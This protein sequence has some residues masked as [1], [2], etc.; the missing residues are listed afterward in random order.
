MFSI[1]SGIRLPLRAGLACV[2]RPFVI[3][4]ES[5]HCFFPHVIQLPALTSMP[6]I[7]GCLEFLSAIISSYVNSVKQVLLLYVSDFICLSIM[8]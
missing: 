5:T 3:L 8:F 4:A 2:S 7:F 1:T 6:P